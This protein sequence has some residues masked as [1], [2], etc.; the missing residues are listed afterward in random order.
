MAARGEH[1]E[2][3]SQEGSANRAQSTSAYTQPITRYPIPPDAINLETTEAHETPAAP[4][5]WTDL[6]T[7]MEAWPRMRYTGDESEEGEVEE[8]EEESTKV[9]SLPTSPLPEL[10]SNIEKGE[11][12][13]GSSKGEEGEEEQSPTQ[14]PLPTSLLP[15]LFAASEIRDGRIGIDDKTPP[16]YTP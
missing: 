9:N 2:N 12:K 13:E 16:Y 4:P 1:H 5:A 11:E 8:E 3:S 7:P 10:F 6:V 15:A 14:D